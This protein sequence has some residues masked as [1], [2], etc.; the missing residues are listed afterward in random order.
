MSSREKWIV[1]GKGQK[2]RN[3][4]LQGRGSSGERG[5]QLG[6]RGTSPSSLGV[7]CLLLGSQHP[8]CERGPPGASTRQLPPMAPSTREGTPQ[9]EKPRLPLPSKCAGTHAPEPQG[10]PPNLSQYSAFFGAVT[11]VGFDFTQTS[12]LIFTSS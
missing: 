5:R 3:E 2:S 1:L 7:P 4:E 8:A 6:G 10:L 9:R 11:E 12:S